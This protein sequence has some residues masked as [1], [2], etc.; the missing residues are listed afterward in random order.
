MNAK[1]L[2]YVDEAMDSK[3]ERADEAYCSAPGFVF[4][5]ALSGLQIF[6]EGAR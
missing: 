2:T 6:F 4:S 1:S 5:G 3:L